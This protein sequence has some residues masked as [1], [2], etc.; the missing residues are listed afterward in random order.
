MSNISSLPLGK[1]SAAYDMVKNQN[2]HTAFWNALFPI[3]NTSLCLSIALPICLIH[4]CFKDSSAL[5][6]LE[7]AIER[8]SREIA[9]KRTR[10]GG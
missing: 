9:R 7:E 3:I 8:R 5:R 1:T 10:V 2:S 6:S 4:S